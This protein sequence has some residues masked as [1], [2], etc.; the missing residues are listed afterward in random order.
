MHNY[1]IEQKDDFEQKDNF[2][3]MLDI[4]NKYMVEKGYQVGLPEGH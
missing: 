3:R 1:F 4:V 2:D